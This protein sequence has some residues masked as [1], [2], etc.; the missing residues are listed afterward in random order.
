M[1]LLILLFTIY[2]KPV[3]FSVNL[4]SKY[5]RNDFLNIFQKLAIRACSWLRLEGRGGKRINSSFSL[6]FPFLYS[7]FFKFLQGE[8]ILDISKSLKGYHFKT[9]FQF[10]L[11]NL[12]KTMSFILNNLFGGCLLNFRGA[13]EVKNRNF[14]GKQRLRY[15][16]QLNRKSCPPKTRHSSKVTP[17]LNHVPLDLQ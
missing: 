7:L 12:E 3:S 2:K 11:G 10:F 14:Q 13:L 17:N 4:N 5:V 15:T 9:L 1:Q 6:N 16:T 8:C